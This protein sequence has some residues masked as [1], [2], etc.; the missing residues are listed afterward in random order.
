MRFES[1]LSIADFRAG[2]H[3]ALPRMAFA[4][5]DGGA[6]RELTLQANRLALD[7]LRL[8]GS[9]PVDVGTRS[10]QTLLFGRSA[11]M[12]VIIGPTGL[13]GIAWPKADLQLA[14]AAAAADIPFVMS[15]AA[16]ATMEEVAAASAGRRWLQLYLFRDRSL[17]E[18][19]LQQAR[20]LEFEAIEIT[21]DNAVAGRRLRDSRNGFS[22]PMTW[23]PRK[24]ASL[25]AHPGWAMRMARRGWR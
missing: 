5:I 12:P 1:F 19:L 11:S 7:R 2:A 23:T 10:Q 17:S 18:R 22:L 21:V 24:I 13:G 15:T 6:D 14:R 20:S 3:S 25:L 16:T 9:A 8:V 4:F